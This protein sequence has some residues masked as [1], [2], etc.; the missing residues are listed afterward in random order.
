MFEGANGNLITYTGMGLDQQKF[1][2]VKATKAMVNQ[3]SKKAISL[4]HKDNM[5]TV[6]M[7]IVTNDNNGAAQ[8]KFEVVYCNH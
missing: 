3:V 4:E 6:G 8:T 1:N 7:N 2:Y 5:K